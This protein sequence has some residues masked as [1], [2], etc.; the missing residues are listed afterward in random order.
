MCTTHYL[1][2]RDLA[3]L[4][5]FVREHELDA[6]GGNAAGRRLAALLATALPLPEREDTRQRVTLGATVHYRPV[7]ACDSS[8]LVIACPYDAHALLARV[9]I[10]SP[11]ALGLLGHAE[12]CTVAIELPHGR[13]L[14]VEI[15]GV[16]SPVSPVCKPAERRSA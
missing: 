3:V 2:Q 5:R 1:S 13:S 7:G 6:R 16:E 8:S 9:T 10:L 11:L 14:Q 12:G 15:V 4:H